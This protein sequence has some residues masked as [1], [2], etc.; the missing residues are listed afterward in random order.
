MNL[1]RLGYLIGGAYSEF[2]DFNLNSI[3]THHILSKA[4]LL[5]ELSKLKK[6]GKIDIEDKSAAILASGCAA[7]ADDLIQLFPTIG[8]VRSFDIDPG[9]EQIANRLN[10]SWWKVD[11]KFAACTADVNS[12]DFSGPTTFNIKDVDYQD[13]EKQTIDFGVIINPS[14]QHMNGSAWVNGIGPNKL[15]VI[16]SNDYINNEFKTSQDLADKYGITNVLYRGGI[17][18]GEYESLQHKRFMVI[19]YR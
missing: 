15:L 13:Y 2:P 5:R 10:A 6:G 18:A 17:D 9:H 12:L 3:N 14:T 7:W 4:W 11:R 8:K 16:Q 19:G 1:T